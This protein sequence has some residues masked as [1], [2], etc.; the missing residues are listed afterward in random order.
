[1]NAEKFTQKTIETINTAQAMAQENGN[2]YLTPAHLLY[3][4]IDQDGGLIGSLL[5]KMGADCDAMLGELDAEIAKLPGVSGGERRN[6]RL[7]RDLEA[8][9]LCREG[10]GEAGGPSI[11]PSSI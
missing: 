8:P 10:G 3:A 2:Q 4:L 9:A 1:M 7:A 5:T 6:L 11:S